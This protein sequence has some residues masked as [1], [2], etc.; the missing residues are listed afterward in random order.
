[1]H[2]LLG[3]LR[4]LESKGRTHV[5]VRP[6]ARDILRQLYKGELSFSRSPEEA[7]PAKDILATTGESLED[8]LA[9]LQA[10]AQD[11]EPARRLGSLRKTMVFAVGNPHSDLMLVGEGPGYQEERKREP[12]VGP[13][14][15]KLD[16]ILSA[17]GLNRQ[18]VYISNICKFRPALPGQT[19]NN[20]KPRPEEIEACLPFIFREI[21]LIQPKVIVALGATAAEGLLG[22]TRPVGKLRGEWHQVSDIPVRVTYHPSY[23]LHSDQNA[24][25]E[26]RKVWEDMLVVMEKLRLPISEKQ[27]RYFLPKQK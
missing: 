20:R 3:Y 23:L 16:Q 1:M 9:S 12:F 5:A 6:D 26:K 14:G 24:L 25:S 15:Q 10:Q 19:T 18:K 4:Q 13:A 17:M 7:A 21:E 11:W 8:Q 2:P 27:Q 22:E